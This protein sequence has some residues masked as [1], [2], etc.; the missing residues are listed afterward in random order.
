VIS[1]GSVELG[2]LHVRINELERRLAR[3]EEHLAGSG[4]DAVEE[5]ADATPVQPNPANGTGPATS[6]S[7]EPS[8]ELNGNGH[9][10]P[11]TEP[12][13]D[14]LEGAR[15]IALEMLSSGYGRDEVATYLRSTFGISDA[16]AVLNGAGVVS[17]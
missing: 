2:L 11:D 16:E 1:N 8:V 6:A 13:H 3:L 4:K 12:A 15:L 7:A 5:T 14:G 17:G 10:A 9:A